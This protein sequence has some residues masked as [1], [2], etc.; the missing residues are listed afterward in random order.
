MKGPI[1]DWIMPQGESLNPPLTHNVKT[2][3]GFHHDCTGFL[4]CPA[5]MDWF[6][7][8]YGFLL[9]CS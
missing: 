4:L 5:G 9:F 2:D 7:I 6:D 1:L 3:H 8:R